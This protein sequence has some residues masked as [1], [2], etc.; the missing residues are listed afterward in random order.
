MDLLSANKAKVTNDTCTTF[1]KL[2][3]FI[4]H[5]S[6]IVFLMS[7]ILKKRFARLEIKASLGTYKFYH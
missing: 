5:I 6:N 2:E 7:K 1:A 3:I 4:Y